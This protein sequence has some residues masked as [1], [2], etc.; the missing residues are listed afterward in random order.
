MN[1]NAYLVIRSED[2]D[3]SIYR[4][5]ARFTIDPRQNAFSLSNIKSL[6]GESFQMFY[7]IPNIN[8]RNNFMI[9]D[10][11]A[12][13]YP[14]V[15]SEAYHTYAT[16]AAAINTE[17]NTV[18]GGGHSFTWN[19]STSRFELIS[20][21]PLKVTKYGGQKRDLAAVIGFA[22]DQPLSTVIIGGCADLNYTRD[23]YVIANR[24]HRN[25]M[26]QDYASDGIFTDI[27]MVVPVFDESDYWN[28]QNRQVSSYDDLLKPRN[29]FHMPTLRK[30]VNF[31]ADESI[32]NIDVLL[33]DDQGEELYNPFSDNPDFS[34]KFRLTVIANT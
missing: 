5:P 10:D 1:S 23:I 9:L 18:I 12:T 24:L 14:I 30:L 21:A 16:L 3:K 13:S 17:I 31:N 7:S 25:K 2:R 33:L 6:E 28:I 34:Y 11:G 27:L 4:S 26:V 22:Y 15:I 32:S 20:P 8:K 19:V 29:L